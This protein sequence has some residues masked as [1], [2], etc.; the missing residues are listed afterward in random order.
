[1]GAQVFIAGD[2]IEAGARFTV[3]TYFGD[4]YGVFPS[5]ASA[6]NENVDIRDPAAL[7]LGADIYAYMLVALT[8][9]YV[10]KEHFAECVDICV[11]AEQLMRELLPDQTA[12][13]EILTSRREF[14]QARTAN[15]GLLP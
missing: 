11:A 14:C 12:S 3:R 4:R 10:E 6:V 7:A 1:M 8:H 9:G 13:P 2:V 15:A 5:T